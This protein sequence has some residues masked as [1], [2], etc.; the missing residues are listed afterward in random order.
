LRKLR[1][2]TVY[3]DTVAQKDIKIKIANVPHA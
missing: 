1:E 3:L 2:K